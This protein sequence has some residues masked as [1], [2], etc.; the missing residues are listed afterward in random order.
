MRI[1]FYIKECHIFNIGHEVIKEFKII[2][3]IGYMSY[4]IAIIIAIL[5]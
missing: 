4:Q 2:F 5:L 1:I 3:L